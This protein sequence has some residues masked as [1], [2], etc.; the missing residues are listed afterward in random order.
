MPQPSAPPKIQHHVPVEG[1]R[2]AAWIAGGVLLA[3]LAAFGFG[4]YRYGWDGGVT[5]VVTKV[6]PYPAA[7]V[8]GRVIRYSE[9]QEDL[10]VLERFY[11]TERGRAAAGSVFPTQEEL[12]RRVL[13]RLIKDQLA[14]ALAERYGVA[15]SADDVKATYDATIL[16]QTSLDTAGGKARA[17]ARAA[18]TL[19]QLYGLRPSQFKTRV[20]HPFLVRQGLEAA[21]RDD[22]ALNVEKRKKAEAALAELQAGKDFK[23]VALAY[24]E[25]PGVTANG[26]DRGLI[27]RGLLAPEVEAAAFS[28]KDGET[29]GVVKSQFGYHIL[30]VTEHQEQ[31][32]ATTKIHLHEILVRPIQL[33]DYLEAQKKTASI[34][35]FVQ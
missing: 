27:G 18:E 20:L 22:E 24:S 6:L 14:A 7:I 13:D 9:Y 3:S 32:G 4:L 8:E 16:E 31:N 25:D 17:E 33:D 29:S 2:R 30:R 34:I 21:I 23:G 1:R 19:E 26:G 12:K 5:Q 11:E 10:T 15:V 35:I 28:L